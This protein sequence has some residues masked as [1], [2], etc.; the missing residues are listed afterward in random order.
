MQGR[1]TTRSLRLPAYL[2]VP[3]LIGLTLGLYGPATIDRFETLF[4]PLC[5]LADPALLAMLGA[6]ALGMWLPNRFARAFSRAAT[7]D[8]ASEAGAGHPSLM[9]QENH[10]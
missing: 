4:H 3:G 2:A 1:T 5:S 7:G 6:L 9:V 10:R 8:R